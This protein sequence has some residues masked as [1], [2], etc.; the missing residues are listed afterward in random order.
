[1]SATGAI[2]A[3]TRRFRAQSPA[4][5][6]LLINELTVSLSFYMLYPYLAVYFTRGLGFAPWM[7]GFALGFRT[8]CQQG[9]MLFGGTLSDRIGYKPTIVIGLLLRAIGFVLFGLVDSLTGVLVAAA[10]TGL[11]G[12]F[13]SPALRAYLATESVGKRAEVFALVNVFGQIGTFTGPLVGLALLGLNFTLVSFVAGGLFFLM[14]FVQWRYLPPN[15]RPTGEVRRPIWHDWR[16]VF[17]NRAFLLFSLAMFSYFTLNNQLYISLPIEVQRR[18]GSD[19]GGTAVFVLSAIVTVLSQVRMT[20]WLRSH[21]TP[22][23]AVV[24]GMA[25]MSLAFV[26]PLVAARLLPPD[27]GAVG[28]S[29]VVEFVPSLLCALLLTLGFNVVQP[30]GQELVALL[31]RERLVG[32]YFGCYAV[33]YGL[34]A[35]V[36]NAV[37][38]AAFDTRDAALPMLPWL[39]LI[40]AGFASALAVY[41]LDR[42]NVLPSIPMPAPSTAPA[43]G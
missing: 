12:A 13:F 23:R 34:G 10:C 18:T 6:V 26:P 41:A 11:A 31:S 15:V 9:M 42:R 40:G 16:E 39:L 28:L 8:F 27:P 22:A 1:M 32:T 37:V 5:R 38:G 2:S 21:V 17:G 14:T 19:A 24:L 20:T 29:L 36:G 4:M 25:T 3:V 30:F 35:T 33:V 43:D 7:V